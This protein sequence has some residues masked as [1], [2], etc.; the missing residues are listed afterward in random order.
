MSVA[1]PG[2]SAPSFEPAAPPAPQPKGTDPLA[3]T[4]LVLAFLL[5][6]VGLVV[7][8]V[9]LTRTGPRKRAGRGLAVAGTVLG[10]LFTV[11]VAVAAVLLSLA[12]VGVAEEMDAVAEEV[13]QAQPPV[14]VAGED[15]AGEDL[16]GEDLAAEPGDLDVAS[17]APVA[18]TDLVD[19]SLGQ[20][21]VIGDYDVTVL[22]V[23]ADGDAAVAATNE[24]NAPPAGRFVL[25]DVSATYNGTGGGMPLADLE[26]RYVG[27]D[28]RGYGEDSCVADTP[29]SPFASPGVE[30]TAGDTFTATYCFDVPVGTAGGGFIAVNDL[31]SFERA[32]WSVG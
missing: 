17:E 27:Q 14:D 26:I 5:P 22:A 23:D 31:M 4:G 21:A 8:I 32:W 11:A 12:A 19:L 20:A 24:L 10:A 13:A 3:V 29:N 9:A 15:L 6:F 30:L 1:P 7:S 16:A 28:A 18:P 2:Y 25:V